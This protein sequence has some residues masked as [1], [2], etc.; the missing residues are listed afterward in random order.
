M[1]LYKPYNKDYPCKSTDRDY[2]ISWSSD[3]LH[4]CPKTLACICYL[5]CK[6]IARMMCLM[7]CLTYLDEQWTQ[8]EKPSL[9]KLVNWDHPIPLNMMVISTDIMEE[10]AF[11]LLGTGESADSPLGLLWRYYS[12]GRQ[13]NTLV[14]AEGRMSALLGF[15]SHWVCV[16]DSLFICGVWMEWRIFY[17]SRLLLFVSCV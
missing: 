15:C 1:Q 10:L 13:R 8:R 7:R 17:L 12:A 4:I 6:S 5:S 14:Q 2:L 3:S 16:G 9:G 11:L